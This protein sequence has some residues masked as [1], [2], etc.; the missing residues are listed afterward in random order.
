MGKSKRSKKRSLPTPMNVSLEA[1]ASSKRRCT[2]DK[3]PSNMDAIA[4]QSSEAPETRTC[5]T[6]ELPQ[7]KH[8]CVSQDTATTLA[9][10]E[11]VLPHKPWNM[12]TAYER[13]YAV[14]PFFV[15][16]FLGHVLL[17]GDAE[18]AYQFAETHLSKH[19]TQHATYWRGL[20]ADNRFPASMALSVDIDSVMVA[21]IIKAMQQAALD[22]ELSNYNLFCYLAYAAEVNRLAQQLL[23]VIYQQVQPDEVLTRL[24]WA[25]ICRQP[26]EQGLMDGITANVSAASLAV[27][28]DIPIPAEGQEPQRYRSPLHFAIALRDVSATIWL[29]QHAPNFLHT[30]D[31]GGR[32]P[33]CLAAFRGDM[34][35]VNAL[36]PVCRADIDTPSLNKYTPLIAAA[37]CNHIMVMRALIAAGANKNISDKQRNRAITHA[38]WG[39]HVDAVRLLLHAGAIPTGIA[40]KC[41]DIGDTEE[42]ITSYPKRLANYQTC[43]NAHRD[44]LIEVIQ[45]GLFIEPG[46]EFQRFLTLP[47]FYNRNDHLNLMQCLSFGLIDDTDETIAS[48]SHDMLFKLPLGYYYHQKDDIRSYIADAAAGDETALIRLEKAVAFYRRVYPNCLNQWLS[49]MSTRGPHASTMALQIRRHLQARDMRRLEV[50]INSDKIQIDELMRKNEVL[51]QKVNALTEAV[52]QQ[53]EASRLQTEMLQRVCYVLQS[54]GLT[55]APIGQSAASTQTRDGLPSLGASGSPSWFGRV[56]QF[57]AMPAPSLDANQVSKLHSSSESS[58]LSDSF[59]NNTISS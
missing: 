3:T 21:D 34:G 52:E 54:G 36:L 45:A 6:P 24:H 15:Y 32:T 13:V 53:N 27:G 16:G 5:P 46:D 35:I 17:W 20:L 58:A 43:L 4:T 41:P 29:I 51:E 9:P 42:Q 30:Q 19:L 37:K 38:F 40:L 2:R 39:G 31:G 8:P 47:Q 55:L 25:V 44:C 49:S 26:L 18:A 48:I 12:M 22:P 33:L 23:N 28:A 50:Q 57:A 14:M 1:Q 7:P 11:I 10:D 56:S 59:S